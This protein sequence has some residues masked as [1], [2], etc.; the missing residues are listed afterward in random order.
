MSQAIVLT[1]MSNYN[2]WMV[3]GY[4]NNII[5]R[6]VETILVDRS[7]QYVDEDGKLMYPELPNAESIINEIADLACCCG[8]FDVDVVLEY[9]NT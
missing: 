6:F 8:M 9:D 4:T 3:G 7:R 5:S 2:G 1:F